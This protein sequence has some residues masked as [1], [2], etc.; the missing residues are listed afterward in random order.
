MHDINPDVF[1]ELLRF[2]YTVR[3]IFK[4]MKMMAVGLQAA[5]DRLIIS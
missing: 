2:I 4:T 3:L 1:R 5:A